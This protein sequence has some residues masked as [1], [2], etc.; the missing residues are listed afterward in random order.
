MRQPQESQVQ[1]KGHSKNQNHNFHRMP[2]GRTKDPALTGAVFLL[3]K[4]VDI[5]FPLVVLEAKHS[6][7]GKAHSRTSQKFQAQ[8][9]PHRRKGHLCRQ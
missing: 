4:P 9:G 1:K 8:N 2:Q 7:H 6:V 3:A 5:R